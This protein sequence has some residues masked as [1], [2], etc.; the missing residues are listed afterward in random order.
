[1]R[2]M[3]FG[4]AE[5]V[6]LNEPIP[7]AEYQKHINRYIFAS[8]FVRDKVVLD[9]ACGA[10]TGSKYLVSKG[11]KKVVG[12][13]ISEDAIREAKI[14][15]ERGNGAQ[16]VLSDAESLPF[17]SHS[18]DVVISFE[19]IEHLKEP[20]RFLFE[21]KRVIKKGGIFIC[22][23]PN[24]RITTP[25]FRKPSNPYHVKEFYPKEFC[26]LVGSY[27]ADT[28]A[29]GQCILNL[30]D[31][32]K[33]QMI[34]IIAQILSTIP[35]GSKI[36]GFLR[37]IGRPILEEPYLPM[38]SQEVDEMQDKSYQVVPLKS[39]LLETPECVVVVAK[40]REE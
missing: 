1:M 38:F 10:G 30:K 8:R 22:S 35:G 12:V 33:P 2:K 25:I 34:S 4:P 29:Y 11:A 20:E 13:D 31:K 26:D 40:A 17:L 39:N 19:T 9:V 18:F 16:F 36:K 28:V 7:Y 5:S 27:F 3:L 23:T 14:W 37:T 24:K 32:V 6:K 15:N 21:C